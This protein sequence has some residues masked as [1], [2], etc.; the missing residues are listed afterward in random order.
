MVRPTNYQLYVDTYNTFLN[1]NKDYKKTCEEL[2]IKRPTLCSR[3]WKY[4]KD[5]DIKPTDEKKE[6]Q[7]PYQLIKQELKE[8]VVP[9]LQHDP[10]EPIDELINRLTENFKRTKLHEDEKKWRPIHVNTDKPIGIAWLGDPH[11]DD[12]YCDWVTLRRDL[13]IVMFA[14]T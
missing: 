3:L 6:I 10:D 4:R 7:K 12:P 13:N 11:I 8:I 2:N 14:V 1:N 9:N 5:N